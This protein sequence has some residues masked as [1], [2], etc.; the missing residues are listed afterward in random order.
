MTGEH[1]T[2]E[3]VT[4]EHVTGEHVTREHVT[5]EHVTGDKQIKLGIFPEN[6][7]ILRPN[8]IFCPFLEVFGGLY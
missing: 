6:F 1:V 3:H 5:G 4:G 8:F 7:G 2:G